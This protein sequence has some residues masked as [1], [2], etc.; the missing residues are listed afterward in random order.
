M[1]HREGVVGVAI[2]EDQFRAGFRIAYASE[3]AG[4][5]IEVEFFAETTGNRSYFLLSMGDR[6]RHRARNFAFTATFVGV[7]LSDPFA[8]L[9]DIGGPGGIIEIA[10]GRPLVQPLVLNEFVRLEDT[11]DLLQPGASGQLV[12]NC[13]RPL[14]LVTNR[15]A[16]FAQPGDAPLVA[17][18]LAIELRRD[19]AQLDALVEQLMADVRYG[20]PEQRERPL[21][22]LLSL[23]A[24]AAI[25]RWR[26]L[27]D[28]LD[29]LV[30]ERVRQS[31]WSSGY[32]QSETGP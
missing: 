23:R 21:R 3:F 6:M 4:G 18:Q 11:L 31:L 24:P 27:V 32:Q 7:P 10:V 5:P 1:G 17:V 20:P 9:S 13:R 12:V 16:V 2:G 14:P 28:H 26:T 19:D 15:E 8:H 29:P 30:F 25:D 22:L